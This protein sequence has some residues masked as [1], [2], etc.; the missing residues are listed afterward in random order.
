MKLLITGGLGYIGSFTAKNYLKKTKKKSIVIDNLSRGNNF[1]KKYSNNKILNISNSKIKKIIESKKIDSIIH[2]ASLTCVRESI[3]N[4]KIYSNNYSSQIKF[5]KNIKKTK[6]K[7]FIFSSSLSVFEKNKFKKN[8]AP[9]SLYKLKIEKYLKKISSVNFKVI[10]L[11]YPNIIGSDPNG[12]LGEKNNFI[13]RIVPIFYNN[14]KNKK[15]NTLY[16]DYKNK[17][18]H[19]RNYMHVEDVANINL[20]IIQNLSKFKKKFYTFNLLNNKEYNNF[21]VMKN[22]SNILGIK[23]IFDLKQ[24]NKKE[25]INQ[26]YKSKDDILEII[27]YKPK[28]TNLK[29][30][31]MTNIKWFRKIY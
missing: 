15:K 2:L 5:I 23:P 21:Q 27:N 10:I 26:F 13:S 30:I 8:L 24:I 1:A 14:I 28:Y 16:Y 18:Y 22:L 29:K 25:S 31:L 17:T 6:I 11:R 12:E 19:Y 4:K 20:K 7:Y 9:Y 3:K